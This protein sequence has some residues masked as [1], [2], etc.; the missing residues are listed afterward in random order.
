MKRDWFF[1][2]CD[3]N[4]RLMANFAARLSETAPLWARAV[5]PVAEWVARQLWQRKPEKDGPP[6]TRLTQRHKREAKGSS[7]VSV[8][9]VV[10]KAESI[11]RDCGAP[12]GRRSTHCPKCSV[13]YSTGRLVEGARTGRVAAHAPEAAAHRGDTIRKHNLARHAWSPSNQPDWLTE[14]TFAREIQPRLLTLAT[15]AIASALGVSRVYT[16]DIRA[17]KRVP[18]PRH[19]RAL[20]QQVGLRE[21]P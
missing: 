21:R 12:I 9:E 16:A 2:Q 8:S 7:P 10:P 6:P 13:V 4:C 5:A 11:C 18:H 15:S 14:E 19:W 3:G 17:G 20:A 1:E